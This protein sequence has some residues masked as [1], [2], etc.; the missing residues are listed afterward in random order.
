[1]KTMLLLTIFICLFSNASQGSPQ[2]IFTW[3][4][5]AGDDH[6]PGTYV[7]P[8]HSHF[9]PYEGLWDIQEFQVLRGDGEYIFCFTFGF[10]SDPWNSF[11]GFS[12]PLIHLYIDNK[13]GGAL[14][15]V[16][17][18]LTL[19]MAS[20]FAWNRALIITGWWI[21]GLLPGDEW[22]SPEMD[23]YWDHPIPQGLE[24]ARAQVFNRT[25]EVS[26]DSSWLGSP[27]DEAHYYVLIGAYD[28]LEPSHFRPIQKETSLWAFGGGTGENDLPV[29]D[30]LLPPGKEQEMV[31]AM[32]QPVL[33]PVGPRTVA[34]VEE[35]EPRYMVL[36]LIP[37]LWIVCILFFQ[38]I[39]RMDRRN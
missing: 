38:M 4:D 15:P 36:L 30:M 6:G 7:Y 37:L 9:Y 29:L 34:I 11:F 17:P 21:A 14:Q 32:E 28:P 39:Q 5:T 26:V 33:Y 35:V 24:E 12:H 2:L 1:M 25:I 31:L 22:R 23:V 19:E 27:L 13:E 20:D 3:E 10:I 18:L 16:K 8:R